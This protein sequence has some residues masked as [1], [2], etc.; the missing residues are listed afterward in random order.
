MT[1]TETENLSYLVSVPSL[2]ADLQFAMMRGDVGRGAVKTK[3]RNQEFCET[4]NRLSVIHELHYT[5]F[6]SKLSLFNARL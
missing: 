5:P 1:Q 2:E 6:C 3:K 4:Q